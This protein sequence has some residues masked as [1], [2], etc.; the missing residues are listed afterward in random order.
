MT[1]QDLDRGQP[2]KS[3]EAT[4]K[5]VLGGA[6][7]W[8]MESLTMQD[9]PHVSQLVASVGWGLAPGRLGAM[10]QVGKAFG[11]FADGSLIASSCLFPYGR[12][13]AALGMVIVHPLWQRKGLGATVVKR[14]LE[15][16]GEL[17]VKRIGLLATDAGYPLYRGLGFETID[18]AH[19]YIG[20]PNP[21]AH[22]ADRQ[23]DMEILPF[24][25]GDWMDVIRMDGE[26]TGVDRSE[27]YRAFLKTVT[28]T[29]V[30]RANDGRLLGYGAATEVGKMLVIGP[31]YATEMSIAMELVV[32]L[33][34]SFQGRVRIDIPA[35]QS[36][37]MRSLR[38]LGLRE[39]HVSPIM[40]YGDPSVPGRREWQYGIL[41]A[42]LL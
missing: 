13:L 29:S 28:T 40:F 17:G 39:M 19:R 23:R 18:R 21:A 34:Q 16:A 10:L 38:A 33:T 26:V 27:T 22:D 11:S 42:A 6:R 1:Q 12:E 35:G 4:G 5:V 2:T 30:A 25:E 37:W 36:A 3:C 15:T 14:C 31:L 7:P 41:D 8:Q 20:V 32:H 9:E 24:G